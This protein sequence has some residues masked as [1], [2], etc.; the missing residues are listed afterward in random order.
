MIADPGDSRGH[1]RGASGGSG[2]SP[3]PTA[4]PARTL[5]DEEEPMAAIV[6]AVSP[7]GRSTS[8]SARR[9]GGVRPALSWTGRL[10]IVRRGTALLLGRRVS[11]LILHLEA[12]GDPDEAR[13]RAGRSRGR[14]PGARGAAVAARHL[15]GAGAPR[16]V[17]EGD[18]PVGRAAALVRP[19]PRPVGRLPR[20]LPAGAR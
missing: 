2:F 14:L 16:R 8:P 3:M 15:Q 19:R 10:G 11:A 20:A 4:P 12:R 7:S 9:S 18:R 6:T 5:A 13:V 17:G 1:G